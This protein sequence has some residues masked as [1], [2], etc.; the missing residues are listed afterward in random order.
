[1]YC[2]KC[3][4]QVSDG[5]NNCPNCGLKVS[6]NTEPNSAYQQQLSKESLQ[7]TAQG[8]NQKLGIIRK[9]MHSAYPLILNIFFVLSII[10]A[11]IIYFNVPRSYNSSANLFNFIIFVLSLFGIVLGFGFVYVLLD[12]RDGVDQ[13][14]RNFQAKENQSKE[15]SL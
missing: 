3:G 2:S 12:I 14:N 10:C 6:Q 4:A 5:M 7:N 1:M 11:I 15:E 8:I 13:L 9:F